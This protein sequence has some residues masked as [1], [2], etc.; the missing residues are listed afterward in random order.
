MQDL[1]LT[2]QPVFPRILVFLLCRAGNWA[3]DKTGKPKASGSLV[4]PGYRAMCMAGQ[5][6]SSIPW[7]LRLPGSPPGEL[8]GNQLGA[9]PVLCW[10]FIG[11][12][13]SPWSISDVMNWHFPVKTCFVAK[14][15]T[16]C[17]PGCHAAAVLALCTGSYGCAW[18]VLSPYPYLCVRK[19]KE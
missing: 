12:D 1:V 18:D 8:A 11:Y 5:S 14:F 10:K 15:P 19:A 17:S 9:L 6:L 4:V 7:L 13:M 16:S 2:A 3:L